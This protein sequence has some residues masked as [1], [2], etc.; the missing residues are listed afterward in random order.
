MRSDERPPASADERCLRR[1]QG[2]GVLGALYEQPGSGGCKVLG[3]S[4]ISAKI[5]SAATE[6]F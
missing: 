1:V 2:F 3:L 6:K 5:G 4:H